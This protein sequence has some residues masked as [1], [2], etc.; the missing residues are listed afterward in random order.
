MKGTTNSHI[1]YI[2]SW[3]APSHTTTYSHIDTTL[4]MNVMSHEEDHHFQCQESGH[5]ALHC[6]N[7]HCFECDEY[8]HT[9]MDFPHRV[10][11]SGTPAHHHRPKSHSSCHTRSTSCHHLEERYRCSRSRSQSHPHRY[12]SKCCHDSYRGCSRSHHRDN[13]WYHRSS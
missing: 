7:V 11:P 4:I 1:C 3:E 8:G 9:V 2:W 6:F 13:R 12:H 5:I 10:P